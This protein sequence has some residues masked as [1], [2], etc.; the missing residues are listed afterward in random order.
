MALPKV[1]EREREDRSAEEVAARM[2]AGSV[3]K[4]TAEQ[5]A[6]KLDAE[7]K[8]KQRYTDDL[9]RCHQDY[10]GSEAITLAEDRISRSVTFDQTTVRAALREAFNTGFRQG[11]N[12]GRLLT[13]LHSIS[14]P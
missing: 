3:V 8:L 12:R 14:L 9:N 13:D 2:M 4:L 6:A 7:I 1:S 5:K 10:I 11:F